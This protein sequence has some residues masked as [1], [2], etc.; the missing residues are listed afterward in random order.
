MD[1]CST[2][3]AYAEADVVVG[4]GSSH[5]GLW[6]TQN[7]SWSR[8]SGAVLPCRADTIDTFLYQGFFGEGTGSSGGPALASAV[9]QL[10]EDRPTAT[11]TR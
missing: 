5:W 10:P 9:N 3:S 1:Q 4:M 11:R 7:R 2:A 6:H 8:A